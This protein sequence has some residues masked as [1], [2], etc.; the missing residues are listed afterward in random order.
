M[1]MAKLKVILDNHKRWLDGK[2]GE[3][4][5]LRSADLRFADLRSADLSSANLSS[6]DLRGADLS[7]ANLSSADLSTSLLNSA[8][9]NMVEIK[10]LILDIWPVTY[11]TDHLHIGCERHLISEWWE[12]DDERIAQMDSKA[13]AWWKK[14]KAYI[15]QTIE[16]S[17]ATPTGNKESEAPK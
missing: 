3:R 4:A 12:F 13:L 2:G 15:Q 11:T 16:L 1:D 7:S 17:P 6:A 14:W 10:T 5:D 8:I 9:G